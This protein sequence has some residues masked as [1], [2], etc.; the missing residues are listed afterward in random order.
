MDIDALHSALISL[1]LVPEEI[2]SARET[3]TFAKADE[4]PGLTQLLENI[5]HDLRIAKAALAHE[6]GFP[7]CRCCW[8]PQLM[9]TDPE[10]LHHCTARWEAREPVRRAA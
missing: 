7:L 4:R 6:L 3:L 1:T 10:G 8:P 5:E 2:R 9:M